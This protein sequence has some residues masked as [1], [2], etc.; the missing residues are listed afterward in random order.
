MIV[1]YTYLQFMDSSL[2]KSEKKEMS[3]DT[4]LHISMQLKVKTQFS[5]I[6]NWVLI[7]VV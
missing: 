1:A 2:T 3:D 7:K 6:V 4:K 5:K